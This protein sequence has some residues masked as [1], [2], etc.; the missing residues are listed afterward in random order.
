MAFRAQHRRLRRDRRYR[1]YRAGFIAAA[2]ALLVGAC[3][4]GAPL[5]V[6]FQSGTGHGF[7]DRQLSPERFEVNYKAPTKATYAFTKAQ[8]KSDSDRRITLAYDMALWRAS[9]LALRHE[10]PAFSVINRSNDVNV[11]T[12][13]DPYHTFPYDSCYSYFNNRA[14]PQI[15]C[16]YSY[17]Y[18][19]PSPADRYALID[20]QVTLTIKFERETKPGAFGAQETIDRVRAQYPNALAPG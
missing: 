4:P 12:H 9:E 6:P 17:V 15:G 16:P 19:Y 2:I 3:A 10:F 14:V 8:Q 20:A 11:N 13:Y 7:T 18:G 1:A 5:Y